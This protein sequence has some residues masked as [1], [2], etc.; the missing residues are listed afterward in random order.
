MKPSE[1]EPGD[2]VEAGEG[3]DYDSGIVI[4]VEI[5]VLVAWSSGVRC[6]VPADVLRTH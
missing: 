6:W 5:G 4:E 1:F 3:E 2:F